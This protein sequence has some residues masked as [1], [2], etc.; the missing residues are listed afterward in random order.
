MFPRTLDEIGS[1]WYNIK[2][3]CVHMINWFDIKEKFIEEFKITPEE[4]HLREVAHHIKIFLEKPTLATQREKGKK[5]VDL[6]FTLN[7]NL[8]SKENKGITIAQRIKM[9]NIRYSG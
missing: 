5:M 6:G 2:E 9:E 7:Y 4:E 3:A 8:V 1:E